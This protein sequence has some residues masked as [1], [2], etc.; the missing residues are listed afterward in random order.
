MAKDRDGRDEDDDGGTALETATRLERLARLLRQA[1][2][3]GGLVPAQWEVLRYLVRANRLSRSPGA[4]A[5]YLG[6]TKGTVSQSLLTLDR[7][8]LIR[9]ENQPS[10]ER[11]VLVSLTQAGHDLLAKDPLQAI[12]GDLEALGG[13]TRRRFARGLAELLGHE[14]ARQG[15]AS[16]GTCEGCRHF[17]AASS[18]KSMTCGKD[19]GPLHANETSLLCIVH[20]A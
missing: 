8:G 20:Q 6:S 5:R 18:G 15:A 19:G 14:I 12:A 3:S 7:K 16:F 10:D 9:R 1:G 4:L 13:K 17:Q 11:Y 2:H